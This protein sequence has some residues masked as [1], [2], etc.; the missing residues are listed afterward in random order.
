M[1][2]TLHVAEGGQ[3]CVEVNGHGRQALS[4][5]V[6]RR[7][8]LFIGPRRPSRRRS[9]AWQPDLDRGIPTPQGRPFGAV[10]PISL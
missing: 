6:H 9:L 3:S 4:W 7:E 1:E 5:V 8:R 10:V 2:H